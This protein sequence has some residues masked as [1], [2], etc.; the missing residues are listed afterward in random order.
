MLSLHGMAA[1]YF[2]IPELQLEKDEAKSIA[3]AL[4]EVNRHYSIPG[5][6]PAHASIASLAFILALTYGK[7]VPYIM[8]GKQQRAAI[9]R[10][11]DPP[12]AANTRS[13]APNTGDFASPEAWFAPP[14][15][16]ILK[17]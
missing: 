8:R 5:I 10:P 9:R 13:E 3:E 7:R 15:P 1:A 6:N 16:E 12:G 2:S 4:A 11:A 14:P 17:N